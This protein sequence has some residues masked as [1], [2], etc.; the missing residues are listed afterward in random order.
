MAVNIKKIGITK[1]QG[2]NSDKDRHKTPKR[3]EFP[4]I[5]NVKE[6]E[7]EAPTQRTEP[8]STS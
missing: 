3:T 6:G 7:E 8:S 2:K 5:Q 4:E 1:G